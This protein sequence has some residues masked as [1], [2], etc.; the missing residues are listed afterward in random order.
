MSL[1]ALWLVVAI[2]CMIIELTSMDFYVTCFAIGAIGAMVAAIVGL[3]FWAEAVVWAVVAVLSICFIRPVLTRWL[4]KGAHRRQSNADALI[5]RKGVVTEKV[6]KGSYG[7][8]KIDGDEWR[9]VS[10]DGSEIDD[11]ATVEVIGRE[12]IILTVRTVA[13]GE[14]VLSEDWDE[15]D[16][17]D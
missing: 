13:E 2:V 15:D 8:V 12:S 4:H 17:K 3:P 5:G 6:K 7:Y 14:H 16:N 1:W 9:S 10:E 11:G